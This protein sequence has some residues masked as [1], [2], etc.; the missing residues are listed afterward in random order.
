[1]NASGEFI[2]AWG[3]SPYDS[4]KARRFDTA[5]N[6][7]EAPIGVG[8]AHFSLSREPLLADDGSYVVVWDQ[9]YGGF[10]LNARR[11]EA[12]GAAI[13]DE[14][15]VVPTYGTYP[16]Y[17]AEVAPLSGHDFVVVWSGFDGYGF[18]GSEYGFCGNEGVRAQR[19]RVATA[20][21][22]GCASTPATSCSVST[23]PQTSKLTVVDAADDAY[24][25]VRWIWGRGE[26]TASADFGDPT[27]STSFALCLYDNAGTLLYGSLV[28][29]GG[30]C[31]TKPCWK[32]LGTPA[33][34]A[35]FKF[36][37]KTRE[38]HGIA[39]LSL[40]PGVAGKAKIVAKG[41]HELLFDAPAGSPEL[42][43]A[44]PATMQLQATNGSCWEASYDTSG[45]I[46]NQAGEFKGGGG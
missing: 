40:K 24:D 19:F 43:L 41:G 29:A 31:G 23:A 39:K 12:T 1:M 32:A 8:A 30:T 13:G 10:T 28:E 44:L 25:L 35:G 14:A 37:S 27:T 46:M 4:V 11:F 38:P 2:I 16:Q 9:D 20:P 6:P 36:K 21:P 26:A 3:N 34:S 33:G 7:I 22:S 42:P 45:V 15:F 18:C 5:D 17:G